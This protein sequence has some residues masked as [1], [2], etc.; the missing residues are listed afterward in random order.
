MN[1]AL[2]KDSCYLSNSDVSDGIEAC[3]MF[4]VP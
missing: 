2:M 3:M 4:P 1:C